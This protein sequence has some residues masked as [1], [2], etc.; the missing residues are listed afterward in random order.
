MSS[1]ASGLKVGQTVERGQVIG[2]VG[3]TGMATGPHLHFA[4]WYGGAPFS[5]GATRVNPWRL[6]R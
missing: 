1:Y 6:F 4:V 5:S 2:Y 3:M